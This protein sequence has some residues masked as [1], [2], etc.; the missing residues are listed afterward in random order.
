MVSRAQPPPRRGDTRASAQPAGA[1]SELAP[2]IGATGAILAAA[3]VGFAPSL[4]LG[5]W[6]EDYAW[7]FGP[8]H[9]S[10][11][12]TDFANPDTLG[13]YRPLAKLLFAAVGSFG[14]EARLV[15]R[16]VCVALLAAGALALARWVSKLAGDRL[17]GALAALFYIANPRIAV[18]GTWIV[19]WSAQLYVIFA[20]VALS[21]LTPEA[22]SDTKAMAR[23][24]RAGVA[25][26]AL[27]AALGSFEVAV[28]LPLA[29]AVLALTLGVRAWGAIGAGAVL[30]AGL[31]IAHVVAPGA[32]QSH[33]PTVHAIVA[34]LGSVL[35]HEAELLIA[36]VLAAL[37]GFART[38]RRRVTAGLVGVL[39]AGLVPGVLFPLAV[40][41][42]LFLL[43]YLAGA[44]LVG[45]AVADA[46]GLV[47]ASAARLARPAALASATVLAALVAHGSVSGLVEREWEMRDSRVLVDALAAND[48]LG[49]RPA[50]IAPL[51][52]DERDRRRAFLS[53]P[54]EPTVLSRLC[55]APVTLEL[56]P[57]AF[58]AP[59]CPSNAYFLTRDGALVECAALA[60]SP[61]LIAAATACGVPLDSPSLLRPEGVW[62]GPRIACVN[63]PRGEGIAASDPPVVLEGDQAVLRKTGSLSFAVP[64]DATRFTARLDRIR[65]FGAKRGAT[66]PAI[67]RVFAYAD[68]VLVTETNV[69]ADDDKIGIELPV[70]TAAV[71]TLWFEAL[72]NDGPGLA[73]FQPRFTKD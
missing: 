14:L 24:A 21:A 47:P 12:L 18:V 42:Y 33:H 5:W 54:G 36:A 9:L 53:R 73:L 49:H 45:I 52:I 68:A 41:S 31:S 6:R 65:V 10:E 58:A 8:L 44:A 3:F 40:D 30:A 67:G 71:V 43:S 22:A 27:I 26:A 63:V 20:S 13:R 46:I 7:L 38:A 29:A 23:R 66:Q 60:G 34:N 15:S 51:G 72:S 56:D 39:V 19:L 37:Y 11:L 1:A 17:A 2:T 32:P 69:G 57:S 48:C 50:R 35:D 64:D 55:G 59:E 62:S 28:N 4:G 25:L 70:E 61:E 16:L